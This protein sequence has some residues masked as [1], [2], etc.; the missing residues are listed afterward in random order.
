MDRAESACG[1]DDGGITLN[2]IIMTGSYDLAP[3]V[4]LD[5]EL[6]YTWFR[7]TADAVDG[8]NDK[9]SAFDIGIG[10]KFTF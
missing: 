6:G 7:N 1:G 8:S 4:L 5:A 9:Y 10:S 2:R 3:G